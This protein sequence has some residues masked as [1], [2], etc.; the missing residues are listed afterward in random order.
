[1]LLLL[2]IKMSTTRDNRNTMGLSK[3]R[4]QRDLHEFQLSN[5]KTIFIKL[6]NIFK[7]QVIILGPHD[8]KYKG[9]KF[10]IEM[11]FSDRYPSQPPE[12]LLRTH[13]THSSIT[14][15]TEFSNN[16]DNNS[17]IK[18]DLLNTGYLCKEK[19]YGWS[20]SYSA[21]IVLLQ[22]QNFIFSEEDM[23]S[24]EEI[25]T[26]VTNSL[27]WY[28]KNNFQF[29][30]HSGIVSDAMSSTISDAMSSTISDTM[31]DVYD[32]EP[33]E[34]LIRSV[35]S[36]PITSDDS[37]TDLSYNIV[38]NVY[39]YMK[40]DDIYTIGKICKKWWEV[41]CSPYITTKRSHMCF[42]S[43]RTLEDCKKYDDVLGLGVVVFKNNS[44]IISL[45]TP[46]DILSRE[47]F[48]R[49]SVRKSVWNE[50][51][52]TWI[53]IYINNEHGEIAMKY[54]SGQVKYLFGDT[55]LESTVKYLSKLMNSMIVNIL[56]GTVHS[57]Q[58]ALKGYCHI[59]RIMI[60]LIKNNS[61]LQGFIDDQ[62]TNF[63]NNKSEYQSLGEFA[64]LISVS[65]Y[66]WEDVCQDLIGETFDRNSAQIITKYSYLDISRKFKIY[67]NDNRIKK[68]FS[69]SAISNKLMMYHK[70]FLTNVVN[71]S[72]DEQATMYDKNYGQP[73][74]KI[75]KNLH[76]EI[77]KINNIKSY[78]DVIN[79][80]GFKL[81]S[82]LDVESYLIHSV[83]S[84]YRNQ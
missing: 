77:S 11:N 20:S 59:H 67:K 6:D 64:T 24:D 36:D 32:E 14:K 38:N 62:V 4:L 19:Y 5:S 83:I 52:D 79:Y 68:S 33:V 80:L 56:D 18:L 17:T 8:S 10:H 54:L 60:Y 72:L 49:C 58:G 13:I 2:Y 48:F 55:N 70:Y 27:E 39:D 37:I 29:D 47:S 46:V 3:E 12:I 43:R 7:W 81:P 75:Q 26:D 61:E 73:S 15:R 51:I 41:A 35:G 28:D 65:K 9:G 31:S 57:N 84:M 42:Y 30:T 23:R 74:L 76:N 40:L 34:K 53:P 69:I 45:D 1:M 44:E 22:L 78:K 71:S 82:G 16:G 25:K 66:R 63:I 50:R 21:E